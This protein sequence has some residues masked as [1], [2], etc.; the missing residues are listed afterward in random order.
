M[1][2]ADCRP[3][4]SGARLCSRGMLPGTS[5]AL[6]LLPCVLAAGCAVPQDPGDPAGTPE[7]AT[8]VARDGAALWYRVAGDAGAPVALYLHGGPGYNCYD[9][10][11]TA[12]PLLE[13][14][15]RVVYLDQRGGGR[16]SLPEGSTAGLGTGPTLGDIEELRGRLGV[17][18]WFLVGHSF[19]GILALEYARLHPERVAGLVLVDTTA[20]LGGALEHEVRFLARVAPERFPAHAAA[21]AEAARDPGPALDRLFTAFRLVGPGAVHRQILFASDEGQ[22]RHEAWDAE[23]GL[24][25]RGGGAA[26]RA[27]AAEGA[28]ASARPDLMRPLEVPAVLFAARRSEAI[29]AEGVEAAARAWRVPVRW[30]EGSGHFLYADEPEAF[31][32]AAAE[33]IEGNSR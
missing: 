28:F 2:A 26:T 6:L 25:D 33:F 8:H 9:F 30:F 18:R 15:V 27:F 1:F 19:G 20:D 23:S 29:G 13:R 22:A 11:R 10:E 31:A 24:R 14:R 3:G 17:D 32:R 16:S 21:L 5:F 12:G 4:P 7:G